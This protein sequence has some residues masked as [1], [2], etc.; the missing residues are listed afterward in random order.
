MTNSPKR[1]QEAYL[2]ALH[3]TTL[4]LISRL[5]LH[6]LLTA[7]V[8]RAGEL[9][10][11]PHGFIYLVNPAGTELIRQIGTGIFHTDRSPRLKPG[12]GL[13]GTVW[14]T[15]QPLLVNNYAD[16]EGRPPNISK[17]LVQAM[18]GVP[19]RSGVTVVGVIALA[20]QAESGQLF[21][22]EDLEL[23]T[24]FAQ[25]AS[26]AL[27]NAWL[28]RETQQQKHYFESLVFNIPVAIVTIDLNA[29]VISWNPAAEKLFGYTPAEAISKHVDDLITN[30]ALREEAEQYNRRVAEENRLHAI[31]RR[32]RKDGTLVEVELRAVPVF[33]AG[34]RTGFI[35][36]YHD[37]SEMQ[38]AR[39]EAE[40]ASL[41]KSA[42]LAN[43]G[44]E[45]RTPLN[46]IIGFT[47]LVRR[48]AEDVLPER[49]IEN[50]DKVMTSAEH[51]LG[52]INAILDIA[53]IEVGRVEVH[54]SRFEVKNL[55]ELC[56][57]A[58]RPLLQEKPI[59]LHT[60]YQPGLP[61][62]FSDQEKVK[63]ILTNLLGNAAKFTHEGQIYVTVELHGE[64]LRMAVKDTGIGIPQDALEKIFE[65]F[66]QVDASTTRQYG[67]TGLGLAIGRSLARLLGGDLTAVSQVDFG[68]TFTLTLPMQYVGSRG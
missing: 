65:S 34:E 67:G 15:G 50:L 68:S 47:R 46:A 56:L 54:P 66:S 31:T 2:E 57:G 61:P 41:A 28:Y 52:L 8:N 38:L 5:D 43:M 11:T 3:N 64:Q 26:V 53:K 42:F 29:H 20:Y 60:Y 36:I 25:L 22:A 9:V 7:I 37:I 6:E 17:D 1:S 23:L 21:D 48:K 24:R 33:V 63:Q 58:V 10:G 16:W 12:E 39:R 59:A 62:V 49:Q 14:Q 45:L 40:A 18:V 13:S 55:V 4:G 35:A 30:A 44:H 32:C 27:D 19:L 51:L